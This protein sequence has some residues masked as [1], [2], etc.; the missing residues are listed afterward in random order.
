MSL[1]KIRFPET[2]GAGQVAL[3]ATVYVLI[4]SNPPGFARATISSASSFSTN[5]RLPARTIAALPACRGL[6]VHN[7]FPV[8]ASAQ[9]NCPLFIADIEKTAS[10][11]STAL[12]NDSESFGFSQARSAAHR[13]F[14]FEIV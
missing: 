9:K 8:L 2:A 3:S 14:R 12:L 1:T 11:T 7:V 10:P 4:G 13:S 5:S 6:D